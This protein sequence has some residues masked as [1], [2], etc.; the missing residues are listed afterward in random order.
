MKGTGCRLD[1][2]NDEDDDERIEDDSEAG[3]NLFAGSR[4]RGIRFFKIA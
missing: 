2:D 1:N 3:P 4:R